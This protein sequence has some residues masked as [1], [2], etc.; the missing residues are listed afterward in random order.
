MKQILAFLLLSLSSY[1]LAQ[2]ADCPS[3]DLRNRNWPA[4]HYHQPG[5]SWCYAVVTSDLISAEI[6]TP[7]SAVALAN[8]TERSKDTYEDKAKAFF[9]RD[10]S[11]LYRFSFI[12]QSYENALAAVKKSQVCRTTIL[13]QLRDTKNVRDIYLD[14]VFYDL[15]NLRKGNSAEFR[16]KLHAL[17]D[18]VKSDFA[19]QLFA[20][21]LKNKKPLIDL[22]VD[23]SCGQ[24]LDVSKLALFTKD[25]NKISTDEAI[26]TIN[27]LLLAGKAVGIGYH[28]Q[29]ISQP[30]YASRE[31]TNHAST[32]VGQYF[33][34]S[35]KACK[36][37]IR[38]TDEFT[39]QI[40]APSVPCQKGHFI[41]P[42]E[43]ALQAM[44]NFMWLQ[45]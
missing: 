4:L 11:F 42:R 45:H 3:V 18:S 9:Y 37:I 39:C 38:A 5:K 2:N 24:S 21:T 8:Y 30:Q 43:T 19:E 12:G 23:L 14:E 40:A 7:I 29:V 17:F 33:D 13:D 22:A 32:L 41:L 6:N 10:S 28:D 16:A 27:K 36:Y 44:G 35:D 25:L 20:V 34:E 1:A 31:R 26:Q 15:E